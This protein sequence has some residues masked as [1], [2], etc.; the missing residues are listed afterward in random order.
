MSDNI[1]EIVPEDEVIN[2]KKSKIRRQRNLYQYRN[3]SDEEFED[4]MEK[5]MVGVET[6]EVFEK[7]ISK[8]WE[9]FETDY[10]LS[11]LKINDRD[12]LRALIQKQLTLE[13]Y[14]QHLFRI[15]SHGISENSFILLEK[16]QRAMSDLTSDISKI[17]NDLMITRKVRKSDKEASALAYVSDL[18][19]KAKKFY[20]S[21]MS[22][23]FCEKCNMLLGTIWTLFPEEERNKVALVC[24]RDLGNGE[25]C[26]HK[27]IVD[28]K[29]LLKK[30]G[31]SNKDITPESML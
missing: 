30:R 16:F 27:T 18:Q 2:K 26:G 29:Q 6:S 21:K 7:R 11:D 15:R 17:Q 9:E 25:K 12:S 13:D 23:I 20:E 1:D 5:K 22:Y 31:T 28:T 10:D 19:D 8:K 4:V 14:E 3:L 24:N